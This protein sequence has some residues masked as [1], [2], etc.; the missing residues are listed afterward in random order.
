MGLSQNTFWEK[1]NSAAQEAE[2]AAKSAISTT[3]ESRPGSW[4]AYPWPGNI[5]GEP[6]P[7]QNK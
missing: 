5:N 3:V 7:K 6:D 2:D 4:K 1:S